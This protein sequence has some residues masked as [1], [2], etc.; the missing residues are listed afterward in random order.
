[1]NIQLS[2]TLERS[3]I[4]VII[5]VHNGGESFFACL[6]NLKQST[7][8][9]DEVIVVVDGGSDRSL[10]V[11]QSFGA[12]VF[13]YPSAGGPA[14]ARNR[15]AE[16][17]QGDILFF[18]DADVTVYADTIQ[19]VQETFEDNAELAALIGSYDDQPGAENFLSQYKNLFHHY[20]HQISSPEASTFWGACGAIRRSVFTAVG[21]F[22]EAYRKP[23]IE[24]IELGYRLKQSGYSIR[25]CKDIQVK[26]LKRWVPISLLQAE[27][28]YR[29]LPWTDL[30]LSDRQFNADLNLSHRNRWSVVCAFFGIYSL[31]ASIF[32]PH[33]LIGA[34]GCAIALLIINWDV[35]RFF[36]Q[37]KGV[38]FTLRVIPWHW[39]YFLYGG[40]AFAYGM[41]SHFADR[42]H[43]P[44][45]PMPA[46]VCKSR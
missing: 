4:S 15:G 6:E 18:I 43:L 19:R 20:T 21:G 10:E 36:H 22:D 32:I 9:P 24:D 33:L 31:L 39:L 37:K 17:A 7:Q 13:N 35:Y 2:P 30:L 28:F 16:L 12:R 5:P 8:Q 14:R 41:L 29:A 26:H 42:L 45:L 23:C 11:A 1:M 40:V 3:T 46:G 38:L 34:A 25:L 44:K 27:I